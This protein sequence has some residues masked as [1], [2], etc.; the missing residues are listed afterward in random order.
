MWPTSFLDQ[1]RS[2]LPVLAVVQKHHKMRKESAHEW[3][4]ID[5]NSLTV[6][7]QK[8]IWCDFGDDAAPIELVEKITFVLKAGSPRPTRAFASAAPDRAS[9]TSAGRRRRTGPCRS[10]AVA[11]H[12]R[13]R[14]A[15][16]RDLGCAGKASTVGRA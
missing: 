5:N 4:A 13:G 15:L 7:T 11:G 1:I 2:A 3:R 16:H 6:N 10:A 14:V 12:D 9:K 8:N